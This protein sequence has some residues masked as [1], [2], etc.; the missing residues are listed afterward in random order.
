VTGATGFLGAQ[1]TAL[2]VDL[3][4]D[5]VTLVRQRLPGSPLSH[6]WWGRTSIVEG[7]VEDQAVLERM[8]GGRGVKTAFHL[9]A[10]TQVGVANRSP[11]PTFESNVRGTW[12]LLEAARRSPS[13][14][15]IVVASSD[16]AYGTQPTLP[17][18]EDMPLAAV[19]PYDV[20]TPV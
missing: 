8:L 1:L 20:S 4:A 6:E 9:A 11:V 16:K 3:G 14:E 7:M 12:A 17:Y 5:V 18:V 19:N 2:L 10:Q 13:V 15:Q